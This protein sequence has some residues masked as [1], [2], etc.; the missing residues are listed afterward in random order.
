MVCAWFQRFAGK[1]LREVR[2]QKWEPFP[3]DRGNVLVHK[4]MLTFPK[5]RRCQLG[6][7]GLRDAQGYVA[8]ILSPTGVPGPTFL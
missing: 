8:G 6:L 7:G 1:N 4:E 2:C 5:H 3:T